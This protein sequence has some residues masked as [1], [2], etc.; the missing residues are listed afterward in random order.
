M[1]KKSQKIIN[2][3]L[4]GARG[5]MGAEIQL[6]ASSDSGEA[7]IVVKAE[8]NR[9][10]DWK[11]LDSEAADLVIDFSNPRGALKA[12]EWALE[13][14]KP[15]VCG[16]TGLAKAELRRFQSAARKIP[17]LY[18]ANMSQGIA[19]LN[20]MLRSLQAL[21]GWDFQVDEVHHSRKKDRPSGTALLLQDVAQRAVGRKLPPPN[22]IRGGGVPGIHQIWAMGP[23]EMLVLQ[24]TAFQRAVFARGALA[25][26]RWLFDKN[27][28]G[29]YD[30]S[31]LYPIHS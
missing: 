3:A 29:I 2:V 15:I 26:A 22:S 18:S 5:R 23:E 21:P 6:L 14:S 28:A 16:T 4:S 11:R 10:Q 1:S 8:I 30:L 31:D 13:N 9:A 24:H 27:T 19:A 20:S 17:V 12:L 7:Q 25:A